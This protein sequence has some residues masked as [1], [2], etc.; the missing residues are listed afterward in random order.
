MGGRVPSRGGA[1]PG[2]ETPPPGPSALPGIGAVKVIGLGG[3]GA[4]VAQALAQYLACRPAPP[5][6][7]LVDGDTYEERNRERVVF[8]ACESKAV[9]KARELTR[10]IRGRVT[11]VPVAEYVAPGNVRRLIGEGDLIFLAVDNHASRALV[12]RRCARLARVTLISGG[13]DGVEGGQGG[14]FGNVQI[15][16]REGGRERTNAITRFHPEIARPADTRPDQD[17]GCAELAPAAPQL[18]FTN[19]AVAAAML[20]TF[21]AWLAGTLDWEEVYLDIARGRMTPVQRRL[22]ARGRRRRPAPAA[23]PGISDQG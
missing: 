11:I 14:T 23:L 5:A 10:A 3:I 8:E 7:W 1:L 4:P 9:V 17:D 12:S 18:L 21:H 13:N 20:G 15:Y 6:M 16:L 2:R 22:G 19:L